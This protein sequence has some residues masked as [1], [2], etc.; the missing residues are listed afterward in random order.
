MTGLFADIGL[1]GKKETDRTHVTAVTIAE[2]TGKAI[3]LGVRSL[4][5]RDVIAF[6]NTLLLQVDEVKAW[7]PRRLTVVDQG[8]I[9]PVTQPFLY[10]LVTFYQPLEFRR[11]GPG[12]QCR[13][14]PHT[15][16][17]YQQQYQ[18]QPASRTV[19]AY[20]LYPQM[21]C[22]HETIPADEPIGFSLAGFVRLSMKYRF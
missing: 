18:A 1:A 2:G 4:A 9:L 7:L 19:T 11:R 5:M 13:P 15:G 6:Y 21:A 12:F 22:G 3:V 16:E 17:Q 8:G 20:Y 14:G 10:L